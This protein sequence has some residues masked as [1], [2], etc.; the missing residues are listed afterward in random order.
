MKNPHIAV[1]PDCTTGRYA[2]ARQHFDVDYGISKSAEI[3]QGLIGL[4]KPDKLVN[5]VAASWGLARP[6]AVL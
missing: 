1:P 3:F 4:I 6:R 2:P 5:G